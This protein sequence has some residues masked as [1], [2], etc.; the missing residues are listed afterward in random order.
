MQSCSLCTGATD[1]DVQS[2]RLCGT[3]VASLGLEHTLWAGL[4][5]PRVRI[6]L[7]VTADQFLAHSAPQVPLLL[8]ADDNDGGDA[9]TSRRVL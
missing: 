6:P 2:G 8:N 3:A 5:G 9:G 1:R 7:T 4:R